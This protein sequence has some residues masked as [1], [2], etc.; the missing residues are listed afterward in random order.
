MKRFQL[1][2][3]VKSLNQKLNE[4]YIFPDKSQ[5]ISA[6]L[7]KQLKNG[8]Y[9][10][11]KDRSILA[12]KL[13]ED[14]QSVHHDG[15]LGVSYDPN[16]ARDLL[17]PRSP[18][19]R[20]SDTTAIHEARVS[21]FGFTN[22]SILDGNIGYI[23]F[24]QF[25]GFVEESM[26]V[27][28]SAFRFVSNTKA[29]IIDLRENGGGSPWMV[30]R[31]ASFF[32]QDK[33][34]LNDIYER[35]NNKTV[36]FYAEPEKANNF[37]LSQPLYVLTSRQTFSAAEDF[38]YAMQVNKRALIVG[39]TTGGGAHPTT[40][41]PIGQGYVA[42]IPYARSINH[43][44]KTDWEGTGVRPDIAISSE[45]AL[46][47]AQMHFLKNSLSSAFGQGERLVIAW[48]MNY[49]KMPPHELTLD[50][51]SLDDYS[52][53]FKDFQF[54]VRDGKLYCVGRGGGKFFMTPIEH[55]LF[56]GLS[57]LQLQFLRDKDNHV[58][59]LKL[60][61]KAGWEEVLERDQ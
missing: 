53:K 26:P 57:W 2:R 60:L 30:A 58:S 35:E 47:E 39:D 13:Y 24:S 4:I 11:I 22:S 56:L 20:I 46:K 55:D 59:R 21:N 52:G 7:N 34:R 51:T 45:H 18:G 1:K 10:K 38:A 32:V 61:G 5:E 17:K 16:F 8:A 54:S 36:P 12:N 42:N 43:I 9:R 19:P 33:T 49:L 27:L 23:K 41:V 48:A 3:L 15:H 50:K 14:I 31:I 6:Y 28:T 25:N 44:T 29:I 37:K 40:S